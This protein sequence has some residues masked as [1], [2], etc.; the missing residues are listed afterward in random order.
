MGDESYLQFTL[1][2]RVQMYARCLGN[3][4]ELLEVGCWCHITGLYGCNPGDIEI[5][6]SQLQ[7]TRNV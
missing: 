2:T 3:A 6:V 5:R 7:G 4:N 1:R